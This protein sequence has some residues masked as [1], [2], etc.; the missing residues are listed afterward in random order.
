MI[1]HIE[2]LDQKIKLLI[3]KGSIDNNIPTIFEYYSAIKLTKRFN[4]EF[5]VYNDIFKFRNKDF[6][7]P[8]KDHGIDV[9][10]LSLKSVV[11]CK[12]Y[13]SNSYITYKKL[14][15]FLASEKLVGKKL[16][17]FLART[18]QSKLDC[19]VKKMIDRNDIVDIPVNNN[20][21]LDYIDNIKRV[22]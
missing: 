22:L 14:S 15:T 17:F 20:E 18:E 3:H 12:Y 9:I 13:S 5:Y 4:R 21:F 8:Q 6:N 11:Q 19:L 7:F 16:D 1:K 2:F 10:D